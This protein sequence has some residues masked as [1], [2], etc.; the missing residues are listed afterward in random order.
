VSATQHEARDPAGYDGGVSQAPAGSTRGTVAKTLVDV[1]VALAT[2]LTL[3]LIAIPVFLNP[4]WV[5]FEQDRARADAWTGYAAAE[6]HRVTGSLLADLVLGPPAYDVTDDAGR[7]VLEPRERAH[8]VDVRN[9]FG[10]VLAVLAASAVVVVVAAVGR[11]RDPRTWHAI[12]AGA[13]G[14]AAAVVVL[15]VVS[16]VAFDAAFTVFHELFFASGTFTFD[17]RTDRLVQ[18]FPDQFW[19]E[20]TL[21]LGAVLLVLAFVADRLATARLAA[22]DARASEHPN[23]RL[24]PLPR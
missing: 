9:V 6:V 22:L 3:L 5:S 24:A 20:T 1:V 21:A 16:V 23:A 7:P 4:V 13:R 8:L 19:S 14:L 11:G 15:G 2:A 10:A 12:R 18:L 17:P